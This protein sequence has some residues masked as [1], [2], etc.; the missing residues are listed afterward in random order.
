[1]TSTTTVTP[2]EFNYVQHV[3]SAEAELP[4]ELLLDSVE[5]DTVARRVQ[6]VL[7]SCSD[8]SLS[9]AKNIVRAYLTGRL[10]V[11]AVASENA[12]ERES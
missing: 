5:L 7:S 8:R 6:Y 4:M 10:R 1:M 3:I 12:G 9:D 11:H 2:H